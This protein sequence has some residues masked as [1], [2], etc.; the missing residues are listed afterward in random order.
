MLTE[1]LKPAI[2]SKRRG[3]LSKVVL[4]HDNSRPHTAAHT[5][6]T[7]RKFTLEVMAHPPYSPDLSPS[8]YHL[9]SLLKEALRGSRFTLDREV[10]ETVHAWLTAQPKTFFSESIRKLVQQ[11][12]SALKSKGTMLKNDGSVSFLFVLQ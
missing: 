7:I 6:E 8:D 12:P 10:K 3:L 2:R 1:R 5:A 4:L 11:W 9:F